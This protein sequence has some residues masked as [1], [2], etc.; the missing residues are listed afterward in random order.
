M[1]SAVDGIAAL[2]MAVVAPPTI[3][4]PAIASRKLAFMDRLVLI[5][6]APCILVYALIVPRMVEKGYIKILVS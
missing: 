4:A 5:V 6:D 3:A 1:P 2:T